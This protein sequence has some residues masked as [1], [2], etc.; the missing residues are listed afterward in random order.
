MFGVDLF[1]GAGGM[2]L[3]AQSAGIHVNVAIEADTRA[4]QTFS[5]N[6]PGVT[7]LNKPIQEVTNSDLG[8]LGR[9]LI[10]FGGPPC[11]GFSTSNQRT[12]SSQNP[13]NWLF[14]QYLR[15]IK[16]IRPD[17]VVF[18]NVT[19]MLHTEGGHFLEAVLEG[20]SGLQ[21]QTRQ[22][23]LNAM[24]YG[25]PQ[26]RSRLFIVATR[27]VSTIPIPKPLGRIV[28]VRDAIGDLPVLRNGASTDVRSY[29]CAPISE[30]A[31]EMRGA[32]SSCSNHFVSR[33]SAHILERYKHV[34]E[35]GNWTHIPAH[36][37]TNYADRFRCHTGIY[38]RLSRNKPSIV[39]GN[40][41]KN[42]LIHPTQNR[43]LSIREAAR[44]Q[45]FPDNY[46]FTG[47]IGFQQQQVGNAVPPK[48]AE[49][50]FHA[51]CRLND[52]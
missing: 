37:M 17:F 52:G 8:N 46:V 23:V 14:R 15:I 41:R 10:V 4:A 38:R 7:V 18:E 36:L 30:Y 22:F 13:A 24:E 9:P 3:G 34:P 19:G 33:N 50:V 26:N 29:R 21:Y 43:G 39:I 45:S 35:G 40:F 20:F 27:A 28:T 16:V 11:Q 12:R 1:S 49:A 51:V 6:H 48:L 2:S 32:L 44:L 25:I 5:Q 31:T 47:S 42:M